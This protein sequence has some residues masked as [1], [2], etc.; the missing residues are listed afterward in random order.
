MRYMIF[1]LLVFFSGV[2]LAGEP[3]TEPEPLVYTKV[4]TVDSTLTKDELFSRARMWFMSTYK[5]PDK[6]MI[7]DDREAGEIMGKGSFG[8]SS[9][10][11]TGQVTY[12][13]TISV[14]QGKYK[15]VLSD[16]FHTRDET[17][18]CLRC[19]FGL[20][21][22]TDVAPKGTGIKSMADKDWIKLRND[23][24]EEGKYLIKSLNAQMTKES[25]SDDEW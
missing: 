22:K 10:S 7:I 19:S 6:V 9:L 20:I 17:F 3:E 16:F 1:L 2:L 15:Y 8:F 4:K 14:K 12:V 18:S 11:H 23:I 24:V 25:Q 5:N 13:I 21:T